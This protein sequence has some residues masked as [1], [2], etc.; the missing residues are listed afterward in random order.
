MNDF[1]NEMATSL[2]AY[3]N[4]A[5]YNLPFS[6][7]KKLCYSGDILASSTFKNAYPEYLN[8]ADRTNNSWNRNPEF[9]EILYS[10]LSE[11]NNTTQT[12]TF[13]DATTFTATPQGKPVSLVFPCN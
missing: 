5:G 3:G 2:S 6:Y 9:I 4:L 8:S 1:I 7:Y 10:V 12:Y 11:Q 13:P